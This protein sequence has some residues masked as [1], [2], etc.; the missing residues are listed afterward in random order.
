MS[1]KD[2]DHLNKPSQQNALSREERLAQ[3]LRR[4]LQRRKAA[5]RKH[6][7]PSKPSGQPDDG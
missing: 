3:T 2:K 1:S 5:A 4:N 7:A 6:S